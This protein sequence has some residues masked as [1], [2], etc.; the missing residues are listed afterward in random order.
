MVPWRMEHPMVWRESCKLH[1]KRKA[2][3]YLQFARSPGSV[4]DC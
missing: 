3:S 4:G 1:A 2:F